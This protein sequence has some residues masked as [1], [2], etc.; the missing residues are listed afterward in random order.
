M[1]AINQIAAS[2]RRD[3]GPEKNK[4]ATWKAGR[5]FLDKQKYA[6]KRAGREKLDGKREAGD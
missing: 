2:M 3:E 5:K 6:T 1:R 4:L